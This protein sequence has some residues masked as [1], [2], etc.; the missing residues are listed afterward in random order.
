M[1]FS[2]CAS[3][4]HR[5]FEAQSAQ[6]EHLG[7]L[8]GSLRIAPNRSLGHLYVNFGFSEGKTDGR[9]KEFGFLTHDFGEE[10]VGQTRGAE[11]QPLVGQPLL[12]ENFLDDGVIDEGIMNGV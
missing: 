4:S 8:F 10:E 11:S 3:E 9:S 1:S 2:R 5:I 6:H 12:A 7:L